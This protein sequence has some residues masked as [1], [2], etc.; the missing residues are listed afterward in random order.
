MRLLKL[1]VLKGRLPVRHSKH[2]F[3]ISE[4]SLKEAGYRGE[5]ALD[6]QLDYLPEKDFLI[7]QDLRLPGVL[8]RFFQID[9]LL[10]NPHFFLLLE[11][12]NYA[13]TVTFVPE[14][15][16]LI[17]RKGD[18]EK[19]YKDPIIQVKKQQ[20]HLHYWLAKHQFPALPT[21]FFI[22]ISNPRTIIK[23]PPAYKEALEK[24]VHAEVLTDKIT[25]FKNYN[26]ANRVSL[27]RLETVAQQILYDS[28]ILQ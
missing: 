28:N 23:A 21:S 17:Q 11:A 27:S 18:L 16:Q 6:Y 5:K 13:G 14:F 8:G 19:G 22:T 2:P 10:L 7:L 25:Q 9:S 3:V 26:P 4:H 20:E 12:K 24:V 15:N 1:V